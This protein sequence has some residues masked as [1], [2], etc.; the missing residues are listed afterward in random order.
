M[1]VLELARTVRPLAEND[2][3]TF[4]ILLFSKEMGD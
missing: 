1:Y 3:T 4:D 2:L